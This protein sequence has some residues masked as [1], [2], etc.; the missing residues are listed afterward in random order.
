MRNAAGSRYDVKAEF[1]NSAKALPHPSKK[2]SPRITLRLTEEEDA[3]LRQLC[4]GRTV[5][6]YVRQR[7]FG[8][9]TARRKRRS[10]VPVKDQASMAKLLG[11][12]GDSRI[13]NNLNQL[14]FHANTG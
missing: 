3:R 10:H 2:A 14:A 4:E 8:E 11:M 1:S 12:L 7:L 5:S 6:A 9:N 13:A